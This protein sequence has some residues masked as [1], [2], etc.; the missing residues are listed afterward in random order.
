MGGLIQTKP[1]SAKAGGKARIKSTLHWKKVN[2]TVWFS[3]FLAVAIRLRQPR[4][5]ANILTNDMIQ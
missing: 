3:L 2:G 1:R 4:P 5:L